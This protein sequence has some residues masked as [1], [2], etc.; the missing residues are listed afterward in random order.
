LVHQ[1]NEL[2]V[3]QLVRLVHHDGV[4]LRNVGDLVKVEKEIN[5]RVSI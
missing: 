3:E 1:R 4:T 5:E 2:L